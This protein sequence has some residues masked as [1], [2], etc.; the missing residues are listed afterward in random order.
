MVLVIII[1]IFIFS[2][3]PDARRFT[4][5]ATT[6]VGLDCWGL[7]NNREE[8][9]DMEAGAEPRPRSTSAYL[10]PRYWDDR[11]ASEEHYEWCKDYSLFRHLLHP[12][13][14]PALSVLEI[15]CGSSRLCEELLKDGVTDVT[16]IDLSSVAVDRMRKRLSDQGIH[17]VK[18]LQADMLDLPFGSECFDLVIEKGTMDVLFVDSGDPWNPRPAMVDK[19]M[20]MLE[21][22]YKV[23]KP[24]GTFVSISFGQPHFRCPL[25][26][27][28]GFTWSVE[29]DR[30]GDEFHYF[31]Y[32][33]KKGRL[34][35]ISGRHQSKSSD[36][37][38]I[39]LL[40]E[41]LEN[42]DYIFRTTIG[43]SEM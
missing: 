23:L 28:P 34:S 7:M 38:S 9:C 33:L 41:E 21:G 12:L 22:V 40:H 5:S 1:I 11:F 8:S 13:L 4:P 2:I 16:C 14:S 19:V 15:G 18:V 10:N 30:F 6:R 24:E 25:F 26:E 29:W 27:A 43:E 20:K 32:T 35:S 36:V 31:F 3:P 42:E 17:G 39:S 37:P